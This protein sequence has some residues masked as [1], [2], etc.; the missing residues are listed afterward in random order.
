MLFTKS[1]KK[2][3]LKPT[4]PTARLRQTTLYAAIFAATASSSVMAK[5]GNP[6]VNQVGYIPA[7][8]KV[9][10]LVSD[11]NSALSWELRQNNAVV[12]SGTTTP[13]GFDSAA[14]TNIHHIDFSSVQTEGTNFRLHVAGDESYPFDIS[15]NIYSAA[16]YDAIKYFY[17][18]RS[19][20]A[21]ETQF[22]GGGNGSFANDA[23]YSRPAGHLNQGSNK[24]DFNVPC[25]PGTCN[26]SLD[27]PYGWYDAGDHGKY[28]VNGGIS[29]WKLA[30]MYERSLF[31]GNNPNAFDDGTLNLP[32][33]GNGVPDILDEIRW[34]M[35]FMLA[36]QVPEGQPNAGMVHHK[37]HDVGWTGIPL[38]PHNDTRDRVLIPPSTSATLNMSAAAAQA[39][40]LWKDIDPSFAQTCLT[41]AQKAWDAAKQNPSVILPDEPYNNGGGSYG[42]K[43]L[44]DEFFWAAAELYITTGDNKYLSDINIHSVDRTDYNWQEVEIP[45]LMSLAIVPT[46]HTSA[47]R[48]AAQEKLIAIADTRMAIANNQG[49]FAPLGDD[50]YIWG[51]NNNLANILTILALAYDFTGNEAYAETVG[52]GLNYL[53]GQN[54]LSHSYITGYGENRSAQPHHRF[55]AGAKNGAFPWAPPGSLIGGPN[56]GLQDNLSRSTLDGC[57][58]RPQTCYLDNID[59]WSTNEITIN[60]NSA[61]AWILAFYDDYAQSANSGPTTNI[62]SPSNNDQFLLGETIFVDIE[63]SDT[64][65]QIALVELFINDSLQGSDNSAPYQFSLSDLSEAP[66]SLTVRATDNDGNSTTSN[67]VH[68]HVGEI[69]NELPHAEFSESA[70]GLSVA[71]DAS[72]S[73][74]SDGTIT[75]YSWDF[76]DGANGTGQVAQHTYL[77]DGEY[78]VSLT[79]TDN[80]GGSDSISQNV[81]VSEPVAGVEC[82][83]GTTHVWNNGASLNNIVV[84]NEGTTPVNGW[85][86]TLDA[87]V[88]V[89]VTNF[90]NASNISANGQIITAEGNDTLNPGQSRTFDFLLSHGG[91]FTQADCV[92]NVTKPPI[93]HAPTASFTSNTA[94]LTA[95]FDASQSTDAD[96]DA[97][98]YLWEFGDGQMA[99]GVTVDHNYALE[100]SYEVTLT[101]EDEHAATDE[102][103]ATITV[104]ESCL[105]DCWSIT[106]EA[107]DYAAMSGIQTETT[108]DINGGINVGWIDAGDWM[109]YPVITVPSNGEY[110]I[111]YRVASQSGGGKLQFEQRGGSPSYGQLDVP[112]TSGWQN[113][114]TIQ[115]T[116]TL[117]EGENEFAIA[118]IS[119]GFNINWFKISPAN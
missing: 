35:R 7:S 22:T 88:P 68:I 69:V 74:D 31:I 97:L 51:S 61:L 76:G 43:K 91:N 113:W 115:H 100:G 75:H 73:F 81:S 44:G 85:S 12:A 25:W 83:M 119:G 108:T 67:A 111:E 114:Q 80:S 29:V 20:I 58:T 8:P 106:V 112:N 53:F 71:L 105:P 87:H 4:R 34:Q 38:A 27:V 99:T 42:D 37:M 28:V 102:T 39:A 41:A 116:V 24:G 33:S 46:A 109:A 98:S 11:S 18:N 70:S 15:S 52:K 96:G 62:L 117:T 45:A 94:N 92:N 90:W 54:A 30:S 23:K 66:Y 5:E 16:T 21:I 10:T 6:H 89:N 48:A 3:R 47:L 57:Q 82:T 60:W 118:A 55:W 36:M 13:A 95:T 9:A 14:G 107:E 63:A 64:D 104:G 2:S 77:I 1:N 50:E 78:D 93:N 40:R 86:V 79:V 26:Y 65:G 17:H 56:V 84:K 49:H 101:V 103:R 59:A 110:V 32:E 72:A 19:G